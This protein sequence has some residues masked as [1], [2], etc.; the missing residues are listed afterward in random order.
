MKRF[1]LLLAIFLLGAAGC[2]GAEV[3]SLSFTA[4]G[5]DFVRQGFVTKDGWEIAFDH[6][7]V[8]LD[9]VTAYQTDPPFDPSSGEMPTGDETV[10]LGGP[11]TVDLAA[12]DENA[13]PIAVGAIDEVAAGH[14]NAISWEMVPAAS[15]PS[16]G[17][18]VHM[19]G[20]ATKDGRTIPFGIQV[21]DTF[22]YACGEFV[23]DERKGI[24]AADGSAEVEM[25]FHFDHVFGDADSPADDALNVGA[26]G[27]DPLAA[28][29]TDDTLM[30]DAAGLQA[31][32]SADDFATFMDMVQTLG[33]VG[34]GHCYEVT[35]G[36]TGHKK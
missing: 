25:T 12:G 33:H 30:I 23:G 26:L 18:T 27:F 24:L 17:Y 7:Y 4:N 34:E 3:G 35:G 36:Y 22:R 31:G 20:V 15:G 1:Y 14:Y 9:E 28:L 6:V 19:E 21:D 32:L 2:S 10:S 29:A 8:T 11:F 16:A 13:D 5:E